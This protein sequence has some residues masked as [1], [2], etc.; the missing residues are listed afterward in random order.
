MKRIIQ[1]DGLRALAFLAVFAHHAGPVA[2]HVG[3]R[4]CVFRVERI[5]DHRY[6]AGHERPV[7]RDFFGEFYA[8]RARRIIPPY[9][10]SILLAIIIWCT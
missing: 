2:A 6:F 7:S 1:F 8:R 4:R 9:C 5:P 3:W 10:L